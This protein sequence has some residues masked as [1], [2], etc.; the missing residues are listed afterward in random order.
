MHHASHN[1]LENTEKNSYYVMSH[2]TCLSHQS[3][4]ENPESSNSSSKFKITRCRMGP[5]HWL[6]TQ[7]T[8]K[9]LKRVN[10][11]NRLQHKPGVHCSRCVCVT[12]PVGQELQKPLAIARTLKNSRTAIGPLF[13]ALITPSSRLRVQGMRQGVCYTMCPSLRRLTSVGR[14]RAT[15]FFR[16]GQSAESEKRK[17]LE[18]LTS[19][20]ESSNTNEATR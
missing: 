6:L 14:S 7:V 16:K 2:L 8:L 9:T 4:P 11:G 18:I 1:Y 12:A 19:Q 13:A 20:S 17:S 10:T 15:D 5:W 3:L